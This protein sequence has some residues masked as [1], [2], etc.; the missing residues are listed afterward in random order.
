MKAISKLLLI[1]AVSCF[2]S[3]ASTK[4]DCCAAKHESCDSAKKANCCKH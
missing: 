3:C 4:S 2:A 1:A